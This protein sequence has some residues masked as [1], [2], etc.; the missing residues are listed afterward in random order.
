MVNLNILSTLENLKMQR[1]NEYNEINEYSFNFQLAMWDMWSLGFSHKLS[2]EVKL[3][4][5]P[6]SYSVTRHTN[7][8]QVLF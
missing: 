1:F 4:I 2:L 5:E 7:T 3:V 8:S 6:L